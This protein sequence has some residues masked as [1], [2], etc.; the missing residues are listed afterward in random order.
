MKK[1]D[2]VIIGGGPAGTVTAMTAK[3][4]Y[5]D[6]S[7]AIIQKEAKQPVPCGIPYVFHE[8]AGAEQNLMK[9]N[10]FNTAGKDFFEG[11]VTL[12]APSNKYVELESGERIG[13]EK[14]VLAAGSRP[15]VPDFLNIG[16]F[17]QGIA[18]VAKSFPELEKLKKQT[19]A[20][21]KIIVLGSGF[22]AVEIAEQ[23][24]KN[25]EKEVHL[26]FRAAHC[27]N[28]SFS[29][30]FGEK[31]DR[32]LSK[33]RL[34]L[35]PLSPIK[36][37]MAAGETAAGIILADGEE[38]SS[39]LIIAAMGF[40]PDTEIAF[41]AGIRLNDTGHIEVDN[42]LR[43]GIEDIYACGDCASTTGFITGRHD[44]IMLASTAAAEAR[45]LGHNLY[46]IRIKRDFPGTLSVFA[47]ELNG[48]VFASAGI[49][50]QDAQAA[51]IDYITGY[52]QDVDR[53]P[54]TLPGAAE[55]AVKLL[56]MPEAGQI[57]GG[58]LTGGKSA[59]EM[60]NV[61]ALAIQ[62]QVTVYELVSFQMATHPLLNTAP[63]KSVL[64]KAAE[65]IVN[66][67]LKS[68]AGR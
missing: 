28:R 51:G 67:L 65:D 11:T 12:I 46:Q 35:R 21:G 39:D 59:A 14:L 49:T 3:K 34:M 2:I 15:F 1:F 58:E 6:K 29:P 20:A 64:I 32:T 24:A 27:L 10:A 9:R 17:K 36:G 61:I 41:R 30:D 50:E 23:L 53:H 19:D 44:N 22:T 18:R 26:V 68:G 55:A 62:K 37:L 8:L 25:P 56:A 48:T 13:Y 42:Y 66:K 45:V 16:A 60:I 31:I 7:I 54:G 5:P 52:F 38:I 57:I 47:T 33:T 43:T 4:Q 63:T 40:K